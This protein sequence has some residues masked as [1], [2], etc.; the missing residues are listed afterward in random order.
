M[1]IT[2][3]TDLLR[4]RWRAAQWLL[5]YVT[6]NQLHGVALAGAMRIEGFAGEEVMDQITLLRGQFAYSRPA[7]LTSEVTRLWIKLQD[8]T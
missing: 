4:L 6:E 1:P 8:R 7:A 5:A 3:T 2:T